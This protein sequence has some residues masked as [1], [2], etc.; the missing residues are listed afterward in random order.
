MKKA[1]LMLL[2]F[3]SANSSAYA[4]TPIVLNDIT[5][6]AV[7]AGAAASAAGANALATGQTHAATKTRVLTYANARP[8]V[9]QTGGKGTALAQGDG[10]AFTAGTSASS[11]DTIGISIGGAAM[12]IIDEAKAYT[13]VR[14]KTIDT[15]YAEIAIG[16]AR[17]MACCG[18]E[19][20]TSAHAAIFTE[21]NLTAGH[22]ALKEIETP[23][24]S[25]S[26]SN[27]VIVSVAHP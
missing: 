1:C 26:L 15:R 25:I 22:V 5:L 19:T 9:W 11:A 6:D 24:S 2:A 27:A 8:G 4:Q 20:G 23:H 3:I 14:T 10:L 16:H 21:Q 18:P 7:T 13:S 12:A 17:S